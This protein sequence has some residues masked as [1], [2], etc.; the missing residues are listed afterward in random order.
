MNEQKIT[1]M[2]K[3]AYKQVV[4]PA[5]KAKAA[6]EVDVQI[7]QLDEELANFDKQ[8]DKAMTELTL[9]AHPQIESMRQQ[10]NLEREKIMVYR[11]QLVATRDGVDDMENG[12]LVTTGEGNFV[13]ELAVGDSFDDKINC[14]VV[15]EDGRVIAIN[16]AH[17]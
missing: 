10:F 15:I 4:T 11:D 17:G 9:K 13:S 7:K 3:V 8:M 14:E 16:K 2:G 5:Y 12:T 1:I 6:A